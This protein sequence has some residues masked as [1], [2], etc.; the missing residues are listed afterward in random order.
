MAAV[1]PAAAPAGQVMLDAR[2]QA[3]LANSK[4]MLVKQKLELMQLWMK[5]CKGNK[6]RLVETP[7]GWGEGSSQ[8]WDEDEYDRQ[9]KKSKKGEDGVPPMLTA[10]EDSTVLCR[11]CCPRFRELKLEIREGEDYAGK[12]ERRFDLYRPFKIPIIC[13]CVEFCSPEMQVHNLA[14]NG[15]E[16][17][18]RAVHDFN[19]IEQ[20]CGKN[21]WAIKDSNDVTK[22][23]IQDN[24]CPCT[25]GCKN[26]FAP[27]WCCPLRT[28]KILDENKQEF[29]EAMSE[30]ASVRPEIQNIFACNLMRLC[31]PG[32]DQY[33]ITYPPNAT[34]E[35][36][37]VL[38]AGLF[39]VEY[40]VFE[41]SE[42][43]NDDI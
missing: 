42:D 40:T 7:A 22:Y 27:S 37:A 1:E 21:S 30:D 8:L 3:Y 2:A 29:P 17:V 4:S 36:K 31:L 6:Y 10:K 32:L 39:L 12:D 43:G 35:D 5:F 13:G 34:P 14:D 24:V 23:Y 18:G 9:K 25:G 26:S 19:C 11:L 20:C 15:G 28:L 38:L 41:H 16:M 33:K